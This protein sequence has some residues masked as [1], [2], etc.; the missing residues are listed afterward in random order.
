MKFNFNDE[1]RTYKFDA[2]LRFVENLI[3]SWIIFVQ[4]E[5]ER[6]TIQHQT[7]KMIDAWRASLYN[8]YYMLSL[9]D[10]DLDEPPTE[11]NEEYVNNLLK[12]EI[13]RELTENKLKNKSIEESLADDFK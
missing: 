3:N 10:K 8:L 2:R 6:R 5:S 9:H 1:E 4:A 12:H 11:L 7:P 13:I